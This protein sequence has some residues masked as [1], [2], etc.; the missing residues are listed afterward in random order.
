MA[1]E[2]I[3]VVDD[4]V[5]VQD[6]CRTVLEN[7][8]YKVSVASNGVAAVSYPDLHDV[9]LLIIDSALRDMTGYETSKVIKTDQELYRKPVLLLIPEDEFSE[10]ES[11][12]LYGANAYLKKPFEPFL[13]VNKVQVLLEEQQIFEQS[14]KYLR[15]AADQLMTKLAE[16]HIQHA[17]EQRTQIIIER[18]LQQVV[19]Q[20]DQKARREVDSRITQLT[21]EKEQELVKSTV[22]EVAR[23]MIDKMAE[24]KV[25]DAMELILREETEKVVRRVADSILPGLTRE[26]VR[27]NVDQILPKEV[28]RRVQ[29]E[30]EQLVPDA[31]QKIVLVIEGAAQRIVPKIA[32]DITGEIVE[33]QLV[34]ITE[35]HLPKQVQAL[36][37]QE[38]DSQVRLRIAPLVRE[39]SEEMKKRNF[40]LTAILVVVFLLGGAGLVIYDRFVAPRAPAATETIGKQT[41]P[42]K[43]GKTSGKP[44]ESSP[45]QTFQSLFKKSPAK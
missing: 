43:N 12:N 42:G 7:Q 34:E 40:M 26:R 29:K 23:S 9:D 44:E 22:Q 19:S 36:V 18:A 39:A 1:G 25:T 8:G 37:N 20:V 16:T 17:V 24:R 28:Q 35:S 32:R 41:T 21:A 14:R 31:S 33:R 3:M 13:L 10:R 4:S 38:L 27:E 6:L 11:Q 30:A 5:A 15:E 2:N 45:L